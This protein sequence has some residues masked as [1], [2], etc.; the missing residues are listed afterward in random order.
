MR[1]F[2]KVQVPVERGNKA[3]VEGTI[4]KV[5]GDFMERAKPEAAYFGAEAGKRT[6]YF[7]VDVKQASDVPALF[8]PL[9]VSLDASIELSPIMN[10]EELKQGLSQIRW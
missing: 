6:A 7:V 4:G 9:F 1:T 3:I 5:I 8:E 10:A 2:V